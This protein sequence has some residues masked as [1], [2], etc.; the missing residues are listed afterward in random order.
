MDVIVLPA[1]LIPELNRLP[2]DVINTREFHSHTLLGH[3]TGV[4]IV[5]KTDFHV[6]ILLSRISPAIPKFLQPVTQ[7]MYNAVDSRVSQN[8]KE[9][10]VINPLDFSVQCVSTGVS[11]LLYGQPTCDNPDMIRLCYKHTADS[12]SPPKDFRVYGEI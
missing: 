7:R 3:L 1:E 4:D 9:W 2:A 8:P 5:R 6:K 12:T 10:K 11:Y